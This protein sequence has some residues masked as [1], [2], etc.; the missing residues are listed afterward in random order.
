MRFPW[1]PREYSRTC[2]ECGYRWP[3]PR[4]AARRR[5]RSISALD[6]APGGIRG[7]GRGAGRGGVRGELAAQ[8]A[9]IGAENQTWEVFRQCPKC[10]SERYTEQRA[11]K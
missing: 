9:S 5:I 11:G 7:G 8:T 4:S 1:Q 10:G 2:D 6:A 3:V